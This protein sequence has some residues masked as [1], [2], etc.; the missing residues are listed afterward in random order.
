MSR[1]APSAESGVIARGKIR[2][3]ARRAVAKLREHLLVDLH[4]YALEIVRA[5]VAGGAGRIDV[6]HDADDVIV[7]FDG[8]PLE[9]HVLTRLLDHVLAEATDSES[10]R[11]RLLAMGVN[12]ALGLSPAYVDIYSRLN[13]NDPT[14]LRVRWTPQLLEATDSDLSPMKTPPCERV[15]APSSMSPRGLRVEV[16]RRVGLATVRRALSRT[17][18]REIQLLEKAVQDLTV[19]LR[20]DGELIAERA[21]SADAPAA[22]RA[23]VRAPFDVRG[24]RRAVLEIVA[25]PAQPRIELLEHGV[26]LVRYVFSFEEAFVSDAVGDVALPVRI[27]VDSDELPTNASRSEIRHDAPLIGQIRAAAILAFRDALSALCAL[28]SGA[29]ETHAG[30]E[31]LSSDRDELEDALS[32]VAILLFFAAWSGRSLPEGGRQVLE[33]PLLLDALGKPVRPIDLLERRPNP[34][35]V[36]HG[37]SPVS[38]ELA[39]WMQGVVWARERLSDR[40]IFAFQTAHARELAEGAKTGAKRRAALLSH[41]PSD[42]V[43]PPLEDEL[44]RESF[45]FR[46]QE[47]DGLR[48]EVALLSRSRERDASTVKIFV[49]QRHID[50]V[51]IDLDHQPMPLEI[52]LAWDGKIRPKFAYDGAILDDHF[53]QAVRRIQWMAVVMADKLA[54]RLD[55][56]AAF[57]RKLRPVLRA[58]VGLFSKVK[59]DFGLPKGQT[60]PFSA[61]NGLKKAAIWP[62]TDDSKRLSVDEVQSIA[63][64]SG[65]AIC[66]AKHGSTGRA[67]DNR[68]VITPKARELTWLLGV[69]G[70]V[71][72]SPYDAFLISETERAHLEQTR[73]QALERLFLAQGRPAVPPLRI[74][75]PRLRVLIAPAEKTAL[76]PMHAGKALPALHYEPTLGHVLIVADDDSIVPREDMAG[77]YVA[78]APM[79]MGALEREL[80]ATI[81]SALEGDSRARSSFTASP[82]MLDPTRLDPLI[83]AYLIT[84]AT[85][86]SAIGKANKDNDAVALCERIEGLPLATELDESGLPKPIAL[87]TL[88]TANQNRASIP[89]ISAIP[90]FET[91]DWYPVFM[92]RESPE[93]AALFEWSGQK[94]HYADSEVAARQLAALAMRDK[95]LFFNRPQLNPEDLGDLADRDA[96][97]FHLKWRAQR[98]PSKNT[99]NIGEKSRIDVSAALP[100]LQFSSNPLKMDAPIIIGT[101]LS[102]AYVDILFQGRFVCRRAMASLPIPVVARVN[103][104]DENHIDN[105][106]DI[107]LVSVELIAS[108]V[109]EA[110]VGLAKFIIERAEGPQQGSS[111]F[112]QLRA[113]R[114]LDALV[115]NA[116]S[117]PPWV[118]AGDILGLL[119]S[120]RLYWPTVQNN[121]QPF[122]VLHNRIALELYIGPIQFNPWVGPARGKADLD[123]PILYVPNTMEGLALQSLVTALGYQIRPVGDALAK[124]QQRRSASRPHEAPALPGSPPH[125]AVRLSLSEG[126]VLHAEGQLEFIEGPNSEMTLIGLDGTP[127]QP[128]AEFPFPLRVIAR[129]DDVINGEKGIEALNKEIIRAAVRHLVSLAK[130]IEELPLFMRAALRDVICRTVN[131]RGKLTNPQRKAPVFSDIEGRFHSLD[132]LMDDPAAEWPYVTTPPPYPSGRENKHATL[133]L[134]EKEAGF[135]KKQIR[136]IDVSAHF[137]RELEAEQRMSAPEQLQVTLSAEARSRCMRLISVHEDGPEGLSG[138]IGVLEPD[139]PETLRGIHLM[140]KKRPLCVIPCGGGFALCAVVNADHVQP[141]RWFDNVKIAAH[142]DQIRDRVRALAEKELKRWLSPPSGTVCERFLMGATVGVHVDSV[143]GALWMPAEWPRYQPFVRIRSKA[144]GEPKMQPLM[145]LTKSAFMRS[146][147]PICAD[148]IVPADMR[149]ESLIFFVM[150]EIVSMVNEAAEKGVPKSVLDHYRWNLALLGLVSVS[151][152]R[153]T[154]TAGNTIGLSEV[155]SELLRSGR[156]WVTSHEGWTEG[157]FPDRDSSPSFILKSNS[158]ALVHVLRHRAEAGV[159]KELG[160]LPP[161]PEKEP[162]ARDIFSGEPLP[163]D[164]PAQAPDLDEGASMGGF[165]NH[166]SWLERLRLGVARF[167][168][169]TG[170]KALSNSIEMQNETEWELGK[171]VFQALISLELAGN[172]VKNIAES[173]RG[174]AI[175]YE[176]DTRRLYINPNHS[177]LKWIKGLNA[178]SG[179]ALSLLLAAIVSELNRAL[180]IVTDAEERRALHQLLKDVLQDDR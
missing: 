2:V 87:S 151:A 175:R 103:L 15:S 32:A 174:R 109:H 89:I 59:P 47:M 84:S 129:V 31:V 122:G 116:G 94:A 23:L 76:L 101:S 56:N 38:E 119:M 39:L 68:P 7:S 117:A 83:K 20:I 5:A 73:W 91:L 27:L 144:Q 167:I 162:I 123:H 80:C 25:P 18:P 24:T 45:H 34:L 161:A 53:S 41:A 78:D 169:G 98:D 108:H 79:L 71:A 157:A 124:L 62:T 70:S 60:L 179:E 142:A 92:P 126:K 125:P 33:A 135:L 28:L 97:V 177:S 77:V 50:T 96:S 85:K 128:K 121:A 170:P 19:P 104:F 3:D 153:E 102:H 11:I 155:M 66:V 30:I 138:E 150:E 148:L 127:Q 132:A 86:L 16:R 54:A 152:P 130:N 21:K 114:F 113:L 40:L 131:Q 168:G 64:G 159:V 26:E 134:N 8:Q 14:C 81:V 17:A 171:T 105:W 1:N 72:V 154:T 140:V 69:L 44:V 99:G 49:E 136:L 52:A 67:V 137:K 95:R 164:P 46:D 180:D 36:W 143:A 48:G 55:E 156:I 166:L 112:G 115:R 172:P 133:R 163:P 4:L 42:P 51:K 145:A 118:A 13:D 6:E 43:L 111:I 147:L 35:Y 146:D 178:L 63:V 176:A 165:L 10:R 149:I 57:D 107:R 158:S 88:R 74:E 106:N 160:G 141:N 173:K 75:R 139:A 61:M 90:G 65:G 29:S 110:A 120:E 82:A 100:A 37:K 12:A 58:A 9:E 93:K 22:P